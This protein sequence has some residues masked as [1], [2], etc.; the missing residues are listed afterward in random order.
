MSRLS[1]PPSRIIVR[2]SLLPNKLV[3]WPLIRA[4]SSCFDMAKSADLVDELIIVKLRAVAALGLM[5]SV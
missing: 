2:R 3:T 5:H 1:H 4:L